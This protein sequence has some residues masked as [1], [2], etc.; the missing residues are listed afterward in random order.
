MKNSSCQT[1]E[2]MRWKSLLENN[3]GLFLQAP[4]QVMEQLPELP[5]ELLPLLRAQALLLH[6]RYPEAEEAI[7]LL[8][9]Q[10]IIPPDYFTLVQGNLL[11]AKTYTKMHESYKVVDCFKVAGEYAKASGEPELVLEASYNASQYYMM[12]SDFAKALSYSKQ[13]VKLLSAKTDPELKI[14]CL[15][16]FARILIRRERF[17]EALIELDRALKISREVGNRAAEVEL[18]NESARLHTQLRFQTEAEKELLQVLKLIPSEGHQ[19]LRLR[20][21]FNL[22]SL[23]LQIPKL[24]DALKRLDECLNLSQ[25]MGFAADSFLCDL[26]NNYSVA[27]GMLKNYVK[28]L[29]YLDE[30][31]LIAQRLNPLDRLEIGLNRAKLLIEEKRHKEAENLL[32]SLG[33]EFNKRKLPDHQM[34]SLEILASLYKQQGNLAA[35]LQVHSKIEKMLK[36]KISKLLREQTEN[37]ITPAPEPQNGNGAPSPAPSPQPVNQVR[38]AQWMLVGKSE[39]LLRIIDAALLAAQHPGANVLISGESGTGKEILAH[40]IHNNSIRR[41]HP[42]VAV[43]AAAIAPNLF[44][45][46]FFGNLKGAYTGADST[47]KG[48]FM[49]AHKGS[50][51]LDE[52]TEMPQEFQ[53]KLLRALESRNII[54]VGGTEEQQFDCRIISSTNRDIYEQKAKGLFRLDL[55]H[56]INTVELCI[57]P[58]RERPEDIPVLVE[59]FVQEFCRQSG[60]KAPRI[61]ASFFKKLSQYS[62]PGNARELRNIIERLFILAENRIWDGILL[63]DVSRIGGTEPDTLQLSAALKA[64]E[65]EQIVKALIKTGGNQSKAAAL[66]KISDAT[67]TRRIVKYGLQN[68]TQRGKLN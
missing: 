27:H 47:K 19:M 17:R 16:G 68:Y 64:S 32:I 46:E 21:L 63:Q 7:V 3:P 36:Q 1:T 24:K 52:I 12:I 5:G 57:P 9:S 54:P 56:R 39:A 31:E 22:A 60:L 67:L 37:I 51:F 55:L 8:L 29:E 42:F 41:Y 13:A 58:L 50:L 26:Y 11:L 23:Y 45:R 44:E 14:K 18:L 43:N 40:M 48:L 4:A 28:A 66:L 10:A 2:Y 30:A 33:K 6:E 38:D 59:F 61:E 20:T 49:Q 34:I 53:S 35:C 15:Q 65:S 62:F 25:A